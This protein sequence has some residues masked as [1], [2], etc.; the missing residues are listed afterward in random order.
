M[1][2]LIH[3]T[4]PPQNLLIFVFRVYAVL[5]VYSVVICIILFTNDACINKQ[6]CVL[7]VKY[8]DLAQSTSSAWL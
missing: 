7:F 1:L 3:L 4:L 2:L 8:Y 6:E 5:F